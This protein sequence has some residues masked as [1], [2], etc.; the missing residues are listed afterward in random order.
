MTAMTEQ[1][2][3]ETLRRYLFDYYAGV[4]WTATILVL[5]PDSMQR[6]GAG[7]QDLTSALGTVK[8][9]E[10]LTVVCGIVAL[11]LLPYAIG[12]LGAP[13]TTI[14][15]IPF[16]HAHRKRWMQRTPT[17][18][19]AGRR[20]CKDR[21]GLDVKDDERA[22]VLTLLIL[23]AGTSVSR[24]FLTAREELR[25]RMTISG[26]LLVFAL[27]CVF[28]YGPQ[29]LSLRWLIGVGVF[30]ACVLYIYA[31][32]LAAERL[33]RLSHYGAILTARSTSAPET[34]DA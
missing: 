10:L 22:D 33:W 14:L 21:L 29:P 5:V 7:L 18:T 1:D 31:N 23:H 34:S 32:D 28:R 27:A 26:P 13:V 24:S 20:L 2:R 6:I 4:L 3:V 9:P 12:L 25:F 17:L 30:A 11:I 15:L 19:D 16:S 8:G